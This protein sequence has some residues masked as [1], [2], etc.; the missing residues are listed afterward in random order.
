MSE[1]E[2]GDSSAVNAAKEMKYTEEAPW[3]KGRFNVECC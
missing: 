2:S 3:K 1:R